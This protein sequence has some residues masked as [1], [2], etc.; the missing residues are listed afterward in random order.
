MQR[1]S[2]PVL[3]VPLSRKS[4]STSSC[5]N[6]SNNMTSISISSNRSSNTLSISS[7]MNII[8]IFS[9]SSS[10]QFTR[11]QRLRI[12]IRNSRRLLAHLEVTKTMLLAFFSLSFCL[13]ICVQNAG[14][15]VF[16]AGLFL[17]RNRKVVKSLKYM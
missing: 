15:A 8:I 9:S 3:Q 11:N 7:N 17:N 2:D 14:R 10:N 13:L 12:L 4:S 5:N 16:V 1:R 6:R